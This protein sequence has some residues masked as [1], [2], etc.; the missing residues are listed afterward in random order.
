MTALD[1]LAA[2]L[3]AFTS[4]DLRLDREGRKQFDQL[5]EA[6]LK[7]RAEIIAA[8]RAAFEFCGNLR[9]SDFAATVL[10]KYP[11]TSD[12]FPAEVR[13]IVASDDDI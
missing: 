6:A 12:N 5:V 7:E 1:K 8:L 11:E 2:T 10:A 9:A 4:D 13:S 3:N